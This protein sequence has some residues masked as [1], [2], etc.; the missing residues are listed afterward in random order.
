MS[1]EFVQNRY[2]YYSKTASAICRQLGFAGIALV[3]IFR[4]DTT[5]IYAIPTEL[6]MPSLII[7]VALSFDLLQY[8]SGTVL[9][10][11]WLQAKD[12]EGAVEDEQFEPPKQINWPTIFFFYSKISAMIFAYVHILFFL[13]SQV[14]GI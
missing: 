8:L 5:E 10:S 2:I 9:W 6:V 7:F 12:R 4:S 1:L 14:R 11:W 3:W 13:H